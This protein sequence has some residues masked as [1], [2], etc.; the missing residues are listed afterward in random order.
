[1]IFTRGETDRER[2]EA[3]IRTLGPNLQENLPKR[4]WKA[5]SL[6]SLQIWSHRDVPH[7]ICDIGH[8]QGYELDIS[9][10]SLS[11]SL[12][13]ERAQNAGGLPLHGA[14]VERDGAGLLLAGSGNKGKSTCCRRLPGPW[15]PLCDDKTLVVRDDQ[16]RYLAHPSPTWTDYLW[17]G[18]ESTW[19]VQSHFP[20]SA[21]F[22]LEPADTDQVIPIGEGQAALSVSRSAAEA[23][24]SAWTC[25]D[26]DKRR[27]FRKKL[28][29]NACELA[30][31][32]PAF[33]LRVSLNGR[34]WEEMEKVLR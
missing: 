22:F 16:K 12:I 9:R 4:G 11:L 6:Y 21:I 24:R 27:A 33:T 17:R 10:M 18:S 20:L 25:L 23:C 13:F 34:F 14:L 1:L 8:E 26:R 19:H 29:D 7:V 5:H 15:H 2:Q 32:T 30:R 28:F 31:S 3:P